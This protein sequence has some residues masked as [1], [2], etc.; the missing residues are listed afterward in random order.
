M[1]KVGTHWTDFYEI[2]HW[3]I[4][5]KSVHKIQDSLKFDKNNVY[6]TWKPPY[7]YDNISLNAFFFFFFNE[8]CFRQSSRENQT[9]IFVFNNFVPKPCRLW[10]N[11]KKYGRVSQSTDDSITRRM[12]FGCWITKATNPQSEY[13]NTSCFYRAT[14][15]TGTSLIVTL[16]VLYI[17]YLVDDFH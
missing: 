12:R 3:S 2:W 9:Y 16:H 13:V 5:R 15:V 7:I 11:V 10:D 4:F 17:A 1:E 6:F 14:M 8:N